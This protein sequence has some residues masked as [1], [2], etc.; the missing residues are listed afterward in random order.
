MFLKNNI[1]TATFLHNKQRKA[2]V[3]PSYVMWCKGALYLQFMLPFFS[4]VENITRKCDFV[5][6]KI[7]L[8]FCGGGDMCIKHNFRKSTDY[9]LFS[10]VMLFYSYTWN[11]ISQP[12][13]SEIGDYRW[14]LILYHSV[15][16]ESCCLGA[17]H[18]IVFLSSS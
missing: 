9:Q 2:I 10:L 5:F 14:A 11:L 1:I 13:T 6:S 15:P 12:F 3:L 18:A 17:N 7:A 16:W 4:L 8:H